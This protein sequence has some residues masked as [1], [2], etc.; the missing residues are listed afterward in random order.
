MNLSLLPDDILN[1]ILLK[2]SLQVITQFCQLTSGIFIPF[3]VIT[4]SKNQE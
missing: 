1:K 3:T 4:I 2:E